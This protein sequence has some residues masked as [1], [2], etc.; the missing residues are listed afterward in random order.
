MFWCFCGDSI[1]NV[2]L[3]SVIK[4]SKEVTVETIKLD[5]K[6]EEEKKE[7]EKKEEEVEKEVE[8][9][10]K[11]EIE[12]KVEVEEVKKEEAE[13][14][15][16]EIKDL[17]SIDIIINEIQDVINTKQMLI[18]IINETKIKINKKLESNKC[19]CKIYNFENSYHIVLEEPYNMIIIIIDEILDIINL[20][21]IQLYKNKEF[22][23]IY[24][25]KNWIT[26]CYKLLNDKEM[27]EIK[28]IL[29]KNNISNI[30]FLNEYIISQ[31]KETHL[32]DTISS[33]ES[34]NNISISK[35]EY[36][37]NSNIYVDNE[38]E[39][40]MSNS[41]ISINA[42]FNPATIFLKKQTDIENILPNQLT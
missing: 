24:V 41:N 9:E 36:M 25:D 38:N 27:I 34:K 11:V 26:E 23:Y 15:V 19:E 3:P 39:Y 32:E 12:E 42:S 35:N 22:D 28:K 10:E 30:K 17:E 33:D 1:K 4:N 21:K 2:E 7:E 31:K 16:E 5:E 6:K 18:K 14:K 40:I 37:I 29:L 8:V 20:S 13:E